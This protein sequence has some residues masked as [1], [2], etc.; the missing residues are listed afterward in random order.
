MP[1]L[2]TCPTCRHTSQVPDHL[3]GIEGK[4]PSCG[5]VVSIPHLGIQR[6]QHAIPVVSG[7]DD[8]PVP[9]VSPV[10][11]S[12]GK[13]GG[14]IVAVVLLLGGLAALFCCGGGGGLVYWLLSDSKPTS[15]ASEQFEPEPASQPKLPTSSLGADD[16]ERPPSYWINILSEGDDS[17]AEKACERLTRMGIKAVPELRKAARAQNPKLRLAAVTILA[18]IGENAVDAWNDIAVALND[19]DAT[20]RVAAA[21]ALGRIGKGA[22]PSMLQLLRA[23]RDP[24]PAVRVAVGE[25]LDRVGAP[26]K[27]NAAQLLVLWQEPNPAKRDALATSV[28][29]LKPDPE[30]AAI[31][32]VPLLKDSETKI[33]IQAIRTLGD[34]GESVRGQTFLKLLPLLDDPEPEV[35]KSALAALGNLGGPKPAERRDLEAGL[36]AKSLEM[37]AF[38]VEQLGVLGPDASQSLPLIARALGDSERSVRLAAAKA[39]RGF[40]AA[41]AEV[42]EEVLKARRDSEPT[43]RIEA[44]AILG[45]VGRENGVL[46]ALFESLSDNS[47]EVGDAAAGAI[48]A[49]RPPLG[50]ADLSLL[51][52]NLKDKKPEVRRFSAAQL[53]RIGVDCKPILSDLLDATKDRDLIVRGHVFAAIGAIGPDAKEAA[54]VL[55]ETLNSVLKNDGKEPGSLEA[56]RQASIALGKI[57]PPETAVP[58]WRAGLQTK[59]KTLRMEIAQS[60]AAIGEPARKAVPDLCGVLGDPDVGQIAGETLTKLGGPEVAKELGRVV[61]KAPPPAKLTA[62]RMLSKMGPEAKPALGALYEAARAYRGKELGEAALD[63]VK[64][65][66]RKK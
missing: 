35:R 28:R 55:I 63:A 64:R 26:S 34:A 66:D 5:I 24:N 62:I 58:V 42:V 31:L 10:A 25:A 13:T 46:S 49:V 21:E 47:K 11:P 50:K 3:A 14:V 33:R 40:G 54:P 29:L 19:P 17:R 38:C 39:L 16:D 57:A 59:N 56:F 32:F 53:A 65:I 12:S 41:N 6:E 37:R 45:L 20:L 7:V 22:R 60:L 61:E 36:R 27:D 18:A 9:V 44:I 48:H 23:S 52:A 30:T 51:S 1:F 2:F 43:V 8:E 4:C 15:M